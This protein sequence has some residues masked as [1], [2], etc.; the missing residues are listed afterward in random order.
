MQQAVRAALISAL[1][2]PGTGQLYLR[3]PVRAC[4]FLLPALA[5]AAWFAN[6]V[7]EQATALANQVLAGTLSLDP[8]ALQA[9]LEAQGGSHVAT[10]CGVVLVLCWV[11]SIVDAYVVGKRAARADGQG[12]TKAG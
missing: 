2:F 5:A 7:M 3:R 6:D 10:A 11:G 4:V 1:V 9:R 8:A 12:S